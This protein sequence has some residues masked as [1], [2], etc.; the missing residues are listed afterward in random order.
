MKRTIDVLCRRA[1]LEVNDLHTAIATAQP[2]VVIVDANCWG[3]AS[4]AEAR[5]IPWLIFSPFTPYLRSPG[6]PPFGPGLR[7]WTGVAGTMR[8]A[9]VRP[10]VTYL[11]DRPIMP[12]INA[13]RTELGLAPVDS[14]D[15]LMRRAPLLLAVGGEPLEYP[16]P[17]WG[18]NVH[19]IGACA[20]DPAP[21]SA[22]T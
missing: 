1:A 5:G 10:I 13:I 17:G 2:D 21:T 14:V 11:F 9:A 6:V 20:W 4:L 22:P 12:R 18:D 16:H 3:A 15:A 8:D 7:R 19:L